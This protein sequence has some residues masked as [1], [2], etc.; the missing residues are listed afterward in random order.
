MRPQNKVLFQRKAFGSTDATITGVGQNVLI[1]D[2]LKDY[3]DRGDPHAMRPL[4][5]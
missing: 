2:R 5:V 3:P 1:M 4:R